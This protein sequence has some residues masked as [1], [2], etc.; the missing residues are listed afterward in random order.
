MELAYGEP[1]LARAGRA[2][3]ADWSLDAL[4][5]D[6]FS[7]RIPSNRPDHSPRFP[8]F[9]LDA[10]NLSAAVSTLTNRRRD[11]RNDC[12]R[13]T[14]RHTGARYRLSAAEFPRG[15]SEAPPRKSRLLSPTLFRSPPPNSLYSFPASPTAST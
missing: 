5:E 4:A 7:P 11:T 9:H 14:A 15:A 12:T 13:A 2:L 8:R 10:H 3:A 6:E 1:D